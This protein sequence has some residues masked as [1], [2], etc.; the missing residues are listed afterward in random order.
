MDNI[1][2]NFFFKTINEFLSID[3]KITSLEKARNIKNKNGFI[4]SSSIY[5]STSKSLSLPKSSDVIINL[6]KKV[7]M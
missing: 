6:I 3:I 2:T 7:K 5:A 4:K 1:Q